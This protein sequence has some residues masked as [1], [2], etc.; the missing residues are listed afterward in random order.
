MVTLNVEIFS[1]EYSLQTVEAE[2]FLRLLELTVIE[3]TMFRRETIS[4]I[5]LGS[6]G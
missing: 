5:T 1:G 4:D 3:T 6:N 2:E